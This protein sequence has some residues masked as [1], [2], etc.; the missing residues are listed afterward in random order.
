[1]SPSPATSYRWPSMLAL[2]ATLMRALNAS[3]QSTDAMPPWQHLLNAWTAPALL[4]LWASA[5]AL[6]HH[7]ANGQAHWW[8]HARVASIHWLLG[9]LFLFALPVFSYGL[10]WVPPSLMKFTGVLIL[11]AS[12]A[13]FSAHLIPARHGPLPAWRLGLIAVASSLFMAQVA[14]RERAWYEGTPALATAPL[15][16]MS[17][18]QALPAGDLSRHWA[19]SKNAVEAAQQAPLPDRLR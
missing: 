19:G 17:T 6:L 11:L 12:A 7:L 3:L 16:A 2:A 18:R 1:M 4:A 8:R 13:A 9:E 10:E 15:P 5:W 14:A